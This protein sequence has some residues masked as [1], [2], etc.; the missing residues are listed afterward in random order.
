MKYCR[1]Q[2][3]DQAHYGLVESVAG[4]EL[5]TRLLLIPPEGRRL[6][7]RKTYPNKRMIVALDQAALSRRSRPS[8]IICV[9]EN[10][11][12]HAAAR[13]GQ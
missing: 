9:G 5:I 12:D 6:M 11:R 13:I 10:Y 7:D 2:L 4:V 3:H 8:K 1:F